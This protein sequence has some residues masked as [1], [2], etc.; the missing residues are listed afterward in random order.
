VRDLPLPVY[1]LG[2]LQREDMEAAQAAG[3][4]GVAAIRAAWI[5]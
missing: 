2:G 4:H 3:A 1:A 5:A